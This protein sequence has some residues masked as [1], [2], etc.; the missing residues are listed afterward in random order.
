[1]PLKVRALRMNFPAYFKLKATSL[2]C[3]ESSRIQRLKETDPIWSWICSS[4]SQLDPW[5]SEVRES[6]SCY[7]HVLCTFQ[8]WILFTS[9]NIFSW[10]DGLNEPRKKER[11]TAGEAWKGLCIH[12]KSRQSCLTLCNPVYCSLPG[13]SVHGILQAKRQLEWVVMPSPRGSS[14]P[15]DWTASFVSCIGRWVI[16]H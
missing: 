15:R 7:V 14:Q 3:R 5:G 1:M 4:L 9:R 8:K 6:W 10:K 16:Y 13:S 11:G 2:S 12:A